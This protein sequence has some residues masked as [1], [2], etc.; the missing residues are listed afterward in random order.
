MD[1][2]NFFNFCPTKSTA[3]RLTALLTLMD[4]AVYAASKAVTDPEDY[5]DA[6]KMLSVSIGLEESYELLKEI[7]TQDLKLTA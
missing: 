4:M 3:D 2:N 5:L 1:K 6:Q 7:L